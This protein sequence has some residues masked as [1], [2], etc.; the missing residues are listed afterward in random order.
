MDTK[1]E[2]KQIH[3]E[4]L[5]RINGVDAEGLFW[6]RLDLADDFLMQVI[7][8]DKECRRLRSNKLFWE[9]FNRILNTCERRTIAYMDEHKFDIMDYAWY[10]FNVG[11]YL[12]DFMH[13]PPKNVISP[14]KKITRKRKKQ[15]V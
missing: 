14:S 4:A 12:R 2:I 15:T 6:M 10:K 5:K 8:Q 9:W 3:Q 13:Y 7:V 1:Q 11:F